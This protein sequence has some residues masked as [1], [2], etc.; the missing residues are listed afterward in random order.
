MF[1]PPRC[2]YRT[3]PR[4]LQPSARFFVRKGFYRARCRPRPI[5]RF[6]CSTC[7]RTFSRQT[8]RADY[9]DHRPH[10]N[11]PL[12]ISLASGVGLRQTSRNLGLSLRST[13]LKF[14]KI[15]RTCRWLHRNLV[16]ALPADRTYVLDEEETYEKESIRP[17][18]MPV[19][20]D[21]DTRLVIATMVGPI[22]RLAPPARKGWLHRSGWFS[23][24]P[25]K[26]AEQGVWRRI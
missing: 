14:R 26:P 12:F 5:P 9:R 15:A 19:L 4:H 21:Q 13:Q 6:R 20:I 18:T 3:C 1:Q 8:F 23:G 22:R 16:P 17:L 11:A 7:R 2:P 10:L 25:G 24:S